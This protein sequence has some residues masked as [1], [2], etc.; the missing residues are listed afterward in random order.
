MKEIN[1]NPLNY[2]FFLSLIIP[3]IPVKFLSVSSVFSVPKTKCWKL[4]TFQ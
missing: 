2:H 3:F 4:E 1:T